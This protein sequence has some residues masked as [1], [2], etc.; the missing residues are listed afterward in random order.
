MWQLFMTTSGTYNVGCIVERSDDFEVVAVNC[1]H[2][3]AGNKFSWLTRQDKCNIP[4]D[5]IYVCRI[6][7]PIPICKK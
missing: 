5:I 3:I 7:T 6:P 1:M 2:H 4:F